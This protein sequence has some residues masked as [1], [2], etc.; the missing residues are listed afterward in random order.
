MLAHERE[1]QREN[2]QPISGLRSWLWPLLSV[3]ERHR[4]TLVALPC[5]RSTN[6]Q[7]SFRSRTLPPSLP[8]YD[9][10]TTI[11]LCPLHP[12]A[13]IPP[14]FPTLMPSQATNCKLIQRRKL[15]LLLPPPPSMPQLQSPPHTAR[16]GGGG[17]L[18]TRWDYPMIEG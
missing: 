15:L 2:Y 1:R 17:G 7:P 3:T 13:I 18:P 5:V 8:P 11:I 4:K 14:S 12:Q 6:Q 16:G 9:T 10:N